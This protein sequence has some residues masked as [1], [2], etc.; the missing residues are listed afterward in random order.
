MGQGWSEGYTTADIY[1]NPGATT[2]AG[3]GPRYRADSEPPTS[4]HYGGTKLNANI[5]EDEELKT[6]PS[7]LAQLKK[8]IASADWKKASAE[9]GILKEKPAALAALLESKVAQ[10]STFSDASAL[11]QKV[12]FSPPKPRERTQSLGGYSHFCDFSLFPDKFGA[13]AY[14]KRHPSSGSNL[15]DDEKSIPTTPPPTPN[16]TTPLQ[17]VT[18]AFFRSR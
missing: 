11:D 3:L 18:N 17:S 9:S 1:N 10:S 13:G 4:A 16:I 8:P 2:S 15:S 14:K 6:T 12:T 5:P 7:D